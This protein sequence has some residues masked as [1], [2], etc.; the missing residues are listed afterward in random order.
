MR[1]KELLEML[2]NK[3]T[4][5]ELVDNKGLSNA[6][7]PFSDVAMYYGLE[8]EVFYLEP[9]GK[10]GNET[11]YTLTIIESKE[12]KSDKIF[13]TKLPDNTLVV[14]IDRTSGFYMEC[15]TGDA[16]DTDKLEWGDTHMCLRRLE[17]LTKSVKELLVNKEVYGYTNKLGH[18]EN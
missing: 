10:S 4:M 2:D 18:Y 5:V 15:T 16:N 7:R 6:V 3:I 12:N 17:K 11:S 9:N 1:V 14:A 8:I 13:H